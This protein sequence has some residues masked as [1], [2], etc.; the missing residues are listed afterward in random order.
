MSKRWVPLTAVATLAA[1]LLLMTPGT[2]D[3]QIR[4]G[5]GRGGGLSFGNAPYYGGYGGYGYRGYG[6]GSPGYGYRGYGY[7]YPGYSG[8]NSAWSYGRG[9]YPG[10][11]NYYGGNYS[12]SYGSYFTPNY[13][14]SSG[15]NYSPDYTY[16][17]TPGYSS[18][19]AYQYSSSGVTGDVQSFYPPASESATPQGDTSAFVKVRVPAE[20]AEVWFEGSPTKQRG[21]EREFVSP[22]LTAGR[23][24]TYE[25]RAR[26]M[27]NGREMDQTRRVPV[28]PGERVTVDFTVPEQ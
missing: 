20:D 1:T 28:R 4:F 18:A 19:P 14:S 5:V 15:Y 11:S 9:Y 26:W 10:Y 16:N 3:A 2:S 23:N 13:L 25:I 24:Y 22:P 12:P 17:Y 7:G 6:Y 8:Y 21:T 27:E